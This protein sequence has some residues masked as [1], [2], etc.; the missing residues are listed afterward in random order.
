MDVQQSNRAP[1][2]FRESC[3]AALYTILLLAA[4]LATFYALSF[5]VWLAV[6][7]Y[8]YRWNYYYEWRMWAA[9]FVG[10]GA[11]LSL[12]RWLNHREVRRGVNSPSVAED[13]PHAIGRIGTPLNAV[14]TIRGTWQYSGG[15]NPPSDD[16]MW[17]HI[18]HVNGE[19]LDRPVKIHRQLVDVR[20][21]LPWE[22]DD[23]RENRPTPSEGQS[24]E[25]RACE[26]ETLIAPAEHRKEFGSFLNSEVQP[27][28][29]S[30]PF[31]LELHG[32]MPRPVAPS[33]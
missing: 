20:Y 24:W 5:I 3:R 26:T 11:I 6:D 9:C 32:I 33:I 13:A 7:V 22:N 17:F 16:D 14:Q 27:A 28:V 10:A 2:A 8:Y 25:I 31:L 12:V 15:K 19:A 23:E 4:P 21:P 29:A 30:R 1:I 18:T